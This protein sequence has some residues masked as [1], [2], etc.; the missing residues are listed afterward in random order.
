MKSV[1]KLATIRVWAH[2]CLWKLNRYSDIEIV[3]L[4]V[5][6][7]LC[8]WHLFTSSYSSESSDGSACI[9]FINLLNAF[10]SFQR[11][12]IL[13]GDDY[14]EMWTCWLLLGMNFIRVLTRTMK[15]RFTATGYCSICHGVA[16]ISRKLG[17]SVGLPS[18]ITSA[19]T[20]QIITTE[21][22]KYV[23]GPKHLICAVDA[24]LQYAVDHPNSW[25]RGA[26]LQS[27]PLDREF[28]WH[29]LKLWIWLGST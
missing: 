15:C 7:C 19:R 12:I 11:W 21:G 5:S 29:M 4:Q 10:W 28:S 16:I 3:F 27:F 14:M 20:I 23:G 25:F 22:H 6:V 8:I 1:D 26:H 18:A 17:S 24:I 2:T 9:N 13:N